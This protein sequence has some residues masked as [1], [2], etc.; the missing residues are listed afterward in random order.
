MHGLSDGCARSLASSLAWARRPSAKV[1]CFVLPKYLRLCEHFL[2]I[3]DPRLKENKSMC[4]LGFSL[5]AFGFCSNI[6][7]N[8]TQKLEVPD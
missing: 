3:P 7:E 8:V 6:I 2:E 1:K 5:N 4:K